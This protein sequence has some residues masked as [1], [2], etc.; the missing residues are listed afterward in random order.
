MQII[1]RTF[2]IKLLFKYVVY[3]CPS[4]YFSLELKR[5][6]KKKTKLSYGASPKP[7]SNE[8]L[9]RLE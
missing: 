7:K 9:I 2:I 3:S 1:I 4:F 8:S 5:K 6:K